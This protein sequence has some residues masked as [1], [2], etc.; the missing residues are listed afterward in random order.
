[1]CRVVDGSTALMMWCD[2]ELE[3]AGDVVGGGGDG[4]E[5]VA[6]EWR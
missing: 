5:G 3:D 6:V 4:S 2:D 1:M